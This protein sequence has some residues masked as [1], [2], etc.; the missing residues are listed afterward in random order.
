MLMGVLQWLKYLKK[1]F[2]MTNFHQLNTK[3]NIFLPSAGHNQTEP[4][5]HWDGDDRHHHVGSFTNLPQSSWGKR[6]STKKLFAFSNSQTFFL[7]FP[8][9][10]LVFFPVFVR[11]FC[12][13]LAE[14]CQSLNKFYT[15]FDWNKLICISQM[16]EWLIDKPMEALNPTKKAAILAFLCNELLTSKVITK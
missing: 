10:F 8:P 16:M 1:Y 14:S 3:G 4:E 11:F 15:A 9:F 5:N 6:G 7:I 2:H 13:S 12:G